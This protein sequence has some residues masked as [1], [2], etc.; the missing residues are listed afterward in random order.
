MQAT[1]QQYQHAFEMSNDGQAVLNHLTD[2]F[3]GAPFV[4]GQ[5]DQTAY[6]CGTQAVIAH[7]HTMISQAALPRL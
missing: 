3:G 5:P 2:M 1:P 6:N 7:I 4:A